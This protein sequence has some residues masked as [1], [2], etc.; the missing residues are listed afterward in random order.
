M[1]EEL[2]AMPLQNRVTPFGEIVAVR[3]RGTLMGNRGGCLHTDRR[4]LTRRRWVSRRWI[5]C[6]LQFRGRRRQV[7]TPGRYTELFFL[8]EATAL[9]AGHR[10]CRECRCADHER[11]MAA[12][13]RGNL[14]LGL[15]ADV[16]IDEVDRV[17]HAERVRAD[18]SKVTFPAR[19]GDLP[20]G[21]LVAPGNVP[22][23]A[24]L[25]AVG[26]LWRWT[27]SGYAERLPLDPAAEVEVLTPRSTVSAIAVGYRPLLHR[28]IPIRRPQRPSQLLG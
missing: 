19:L 23:R 14:A 6:V 9:A 2:I 28:S 22:E 24:L 20:D 12:W 13:L 3:E 5:V 17:L 15:P 26:S 27:A 25:L 16:G 21:V 8:D 4:T 7:M 10:P 11:F 18:G 1:R